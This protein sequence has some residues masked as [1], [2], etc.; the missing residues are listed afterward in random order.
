MSPSS[1]ALSQADQNRNLVHRWFEEVWNQGKREVIRELFLA[2]CIL[3]DGS[4]TIKGP[5]EFELFYDNLQNQFTDIRVTPGHSVCDAESVSLRWHVECRHRGS[6]T[7]VS[8]SGITIAK[9]KNGKFIEAW[10]N[11]DLAGM[12]AQLTA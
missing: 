8:F 10:Q 2:D 12:Q 11:W 9:T 6:G 4:K 5:A 1:Q 3:H 7:P